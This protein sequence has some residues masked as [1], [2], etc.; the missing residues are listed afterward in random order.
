MNR[1]GDCQRSRLGVPA[2]PRLA[3]TYSSPLLA[4]PAQMYRSA[5][6]VM[7]QNRRASHHRATGGERLP[8]LTPATSTSAGL[9][10]P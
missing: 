1:R 7:H 5:F 4:P 10:N 8:A 9:E 2:A 3:I 6:S